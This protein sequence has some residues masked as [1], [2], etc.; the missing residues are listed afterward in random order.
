MS[1]SESS[2]P[3]KLSAFASH[4]RSEG[5]RAA[6]ALAMLVAQP[7]SSSAPAAARISAPSAGATTRAPFAVP[8]GQR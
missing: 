2:V 8:T 4:C 1:T 6:G 7:A 3:M 5:E